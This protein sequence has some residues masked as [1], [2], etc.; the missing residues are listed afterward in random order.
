MVVE[1]SPWKNKTWCQIFLS[2]I[3]AENKW[4][5]K[6]LNI[7]ISTIYNI[8]SY[9]LSIQTLMSWPWKNCTLS[10]LNVKL[11]PQRTYKLNFGFEIPSNYSNIYWE[12][13]FLYPHSISVSSSDHQNHLLAQ[14]YLQ[15]DTSISVLSIPLFSKLCH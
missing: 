7:N 6:M 3:L 13:S 1:L 2:I 4:N 5:S 9:Y 8:N 14:C 10:Y 12:T 15:N 11:G